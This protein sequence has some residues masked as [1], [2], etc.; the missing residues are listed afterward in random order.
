MLERSGPSWRV[1][2][3]RVIRLGDPTDWNA[4]LTNVNG[5]RLDEIAT[6]PSGRGLVLGDNELIHVFPHLKWRRKSVAMSLNPEGTNS[7]K[8]VAFISVGIS[9]HDISGARQKQLFLMAPIA[10]VR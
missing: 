2:E 10:V 5:S 1:A 8:L 6:H 4:L 9:A 7:L 3:L